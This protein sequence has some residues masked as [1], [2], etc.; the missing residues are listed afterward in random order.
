MY[1]CPCYRYIPKVA[2][3]HLEDPIITMAIV[4]LCSPS[5]IK[6]PYLTAKLVE[7]RPSLACLLSAPPAFLSFSTFSSSV[8]AVYSLQFSLPSPSFSCFSSFSF[9]SSSP[10]S[11]SSSFLPSLLPHIPSFL[12]SFP[13]SMSVTSSSM[14]GLVTLSFSPSVLVIVQI[15]LLETD[16][17]SKNN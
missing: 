6:N 1:V 4:L 2:I 14:C 9:S 17:E 5:L 11:S 10:A 8:P 13:P 3:K 7:V 15:T 12:L 16:R